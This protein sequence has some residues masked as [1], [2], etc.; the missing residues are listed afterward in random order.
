MIAG[1]YVC[2]CVRNWSWTY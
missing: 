2:A 1:V